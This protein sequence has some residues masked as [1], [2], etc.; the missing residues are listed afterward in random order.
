MLKHDGNAEIAIYDNIGKLIFVK[1]EIDLNQPQK[2]T[3][4]NLSNGIYHVVVRTATA[5]FMT[6][7]KVMK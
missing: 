1:S 3:V 7:I 5:Q 6:K 2:I 4:D